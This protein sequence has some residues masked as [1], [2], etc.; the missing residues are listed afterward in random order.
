MTE[1]FDKNWECVIGLE[2]HAQ[3]SSHS[4]IFSRSSTN[5]GAKQNSNV[6]FIDA[7]MPG[8]L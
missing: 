2:I 8:M 7:G 5:F 4:K 6:S 3:I 1:N